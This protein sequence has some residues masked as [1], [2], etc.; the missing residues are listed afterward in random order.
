MDNSN[1]EIRH[2]QP[3]MYQHHHHHR[4]FTSEKRLQAFR[5]TQVNKH[6][7]QPYINPD[8][9]YVL[10]S[11]RESLQTNL[12]VTYGLKPPDHNNLPSPERIDDRP[13]LGEP[14]TT[15]RNA[16]SGNHCF[17]YKKVPLQSKDGHLL[18]SIASPKESIYAKRKLLCKQR[19][20]HA[21]KI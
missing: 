8:C 7:Q 3:F 18:S 2:N 12:R 17:R 4:T 21:M 6:A 19:K 1:V 15:T 14:T 20:E 10:E 5:N 11:S 13:Y 9:K 16:L